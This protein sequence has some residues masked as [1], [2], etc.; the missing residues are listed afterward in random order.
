MAT[1]G[2]SGDASLDWQML[3]WTVG[4][5]SGSASVKA[6]IMFVFDGSYTLAKVTIPLW[7]TTSKKEKKCFR[8]QV[9]M[10]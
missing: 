6:K 9:R 2:V 3:P 8:D 7:D 10:E 1:L 4:T 5:L